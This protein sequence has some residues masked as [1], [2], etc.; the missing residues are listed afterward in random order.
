[1]RKHAAST[2]C[3]R[4]PD[5]DP[6]ED[7]HLLSGGIEVIGVFP[8][9]SPAI[10][11]AI[12]FRGPVHAPDVGWFPSA[13]LFSQNTAFPQ[14]PLDGFHHDSGPWGH[15]FPPAAALQSSFA[16]QPPSPASSS[17]AEFQGAP[18]PSP[19]SGAMA[20]SLAVPY[21]GGAPPSLAP[22]PM[23]G[24]PGAYP[25]GDVQRLKADVE[26]L[27]EH[28]PPAKP[29]TEANVVNLGG[30]TEDTQGVTAAI[31]YGNQ[32]AGAVITGGN[33]NAQVAPSAAVAPVH[34]TALLNP[35]AGRSEQS[36]QSAR[37]S[38]ALANQPMESG[39][40]FPK[41]VSANLVMT[42]SSAAVMTAVHPD[43]NVPPADPLTNGNLDEIP[44][45][46]SAGLI[47]D[48]LPL[49]RALLE[50]AVDQFFDRLED[51]GVGQLVEQGPTRVIPLSLALIGTATAME[52][53]R[54]RLRPK[55][56]EGH[57][58]RRQDP[59]GSEELRGFPELPGSWSTRLA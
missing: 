55:T 47:A 42:E 32:G 14:M 34:M 15:P 16:S 4:R 8:T 44:L 37:M 49:D 13:P 38:E 54:R 20:A 22:P 1:M 46:H 40:G 53:A 12:D 35:E 31:I 28:G 23:P 24:P 18:G 56:G 10:I 59:L 33:A 19:V 52:V 57:T 17:A 11:V 29:L 25:P 36:I 21:Q 39:H 7:R 48:V 5:L 45:P 3:N 6:L 2:T 27:R 30:S 41:T 50:Q 51:L 9:P 43:G 26:F 58:A